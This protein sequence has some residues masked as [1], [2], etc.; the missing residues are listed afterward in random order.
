VIACDV[1]EVWVEVLVLGVVRW[2]REGDRTEA[3]CG[4]VGVA[5]WGTCWWKRQSWIGEGKVMVCILDE[6]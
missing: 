6:L 5:Y 3:C 4:L 1:V 2:W